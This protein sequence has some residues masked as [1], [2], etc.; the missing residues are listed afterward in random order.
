MATRLLKG[1]GRRLGVFLVTGTVMYC[2]VVVASVLQLSP[3]FGVTAFLTL[4][5][6]AFMRER[7]IR[8]MF[9]GALAA[10]SKESGALLFAVELGVYV[11]VF[12]LR[13][14]N[15]LPR[16]WQAFRR[17]S[18]LVVVPLVGVLA[19]FAV[20]APQDENAM[21]ATRLDL[22][23]VVR[24]FLSV[25]F[26]DNVLPASLATIFVLNCMW[27]PTAVLVLCVGYWVVRR[28]LLA[29]PT[30]TS[31][32]PA[33][34]FAV[35]SFLLSAYLL[36]RFRTFTNVRYY[37][38]VFPLVLL[39]SARA[40]WSIGL[41]RLVRL[42]GQG[43]ILLAL[44][45]SN[46]RSFDPVS[47]DLF[48]TLRFGEHR[49]FHITSLTGEC[50]GLGRDQM[51]YNLEFAEMEWLSRQIYP[52]VFRARND[53]YE[54][55]AHPEADWRFFDSIDA[56]TLRRGSPRPGSFVLPRT[57][58][59]AVGAVPVKPE[60]ILYIAFPNMPNQNELSRYQ[61]WYAIRDVKRRFSHHGYSIDVLELR[62]KH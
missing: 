11:L 43:G 58:S 12:G 6:R 23:S 27:V 3:D 32:D 10:L 13:A 8:A 52:F 47:A 34:E 40:L 49:L 20:I 1:E 9:W 36:T 53:G 28:W 35:V 51:V 50:C 24:Q 30:R 7:Y 19:V 48:G 21:W 18:A 60:K 44:G 41:P 31:R 45:W 29:L 25:S 46:F 33:F 4:A 37:L 39:L 2:P 54:T 38:P 5:A 22:Q 26:M 56:K 57:H 42:L 16:K 55:A 17:R 62:L 61:N 59:W 15:L 14:P